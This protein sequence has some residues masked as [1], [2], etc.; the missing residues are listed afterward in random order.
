MCTSRS[1]YSSKGFAYVLWL[2]WVECGDLLKEKMYHFP[3]IKKKLERK[4]VKEQEAL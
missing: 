3:K 4:K 2:R 1:V